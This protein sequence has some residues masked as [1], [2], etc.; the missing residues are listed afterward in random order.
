MLPLFSYEDCLVKL[1]WDLDDLLQQ[2]QL[3]Q[4]EYRYHCMST[5]FNSKGFMDVNMNICSSNTPIPDS[6]TDDLS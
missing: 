3:S 4:T 5:C 6:E 2:D 1:F